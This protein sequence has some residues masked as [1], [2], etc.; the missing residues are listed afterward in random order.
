MRFSSMRAVMGDRFVS[1]GQH[2]EEKQ[3]GIWDCGSNQEISLAEEQFG[4]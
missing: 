1:W 2:C 4:G 3:R